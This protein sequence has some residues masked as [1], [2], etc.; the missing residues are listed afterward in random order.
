MS[1]A[2]NDTLELTVH[3]TGFLLDRLGADCHP[4]QFLRE[5]TQNSIEAILRTPTKTGEI[6]WDVDWTP[7]EVG[8]HLAYKLCITDNA[9]PMAAPGPDVPAPS[10]WVARYLNTR[11]FR[12]PDG[13]SLKAREGWTFPRSNGD[14]NKLR[15]VTGQEPYLREHALASGEVAL[16]D[17]TA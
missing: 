6:V 3:N 2:A 8:Q 9:D 17:A 12:L 14:T 10:R 5:L 4:L 16:T 11:Y 13:I 15:A 7:Y 1:L